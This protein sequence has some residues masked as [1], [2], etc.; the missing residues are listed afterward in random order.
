M[1]VCARSGWGGSCGR[2]GTARVAG[3]GLNHAA[4]GGFMALDHPGAAG[5]GHAPVLH[6][7][8]PGERQRPPGALQPGALQDPGQAGEAKTAE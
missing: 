5:L 2:S 4:L 3:L 6:R 1:R 7:R 8:S